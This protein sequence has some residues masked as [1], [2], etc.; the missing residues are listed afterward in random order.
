[1]KIHQRK[2]TGEKPYMCT[3]C[4]KSFSQ[5][6][7]LNTHKR[8]IHGN[9]GKTKGSKQHDIPVEDVY[10]REPSPE[11]IVD[12]KKVKYICATQ[13]N[14][15]NG[16][17][18]KC[19]GCSLEYNSIKTLE[20]H[21]TIHSGEKRYMCKICDKRFRTPRM[22]TEHWFTHKENENAKKFQCEKCAKIFAFKNQL[23]RHQ[24][25][26]HDEK[27]YG[28][29]HCPKKF[30]TVGI[31]TKHIKLKHKSK[32]KVHLCNHCG[33]GFDNPSQ[34][35]V[36]IRD[37][38]EEKKLACNECG[39]KFSGK[40]RL[41]RHIFYIHSGVEGFIPCLE[42]TCQKLFKV[43]SAMRN[44]HRTVHQKITYFCPICQ[45]PGFTSKNW[46]THRKKF[47]PE[48]IRSYFK[49]ETPTPTIL[50]QTT[51]KVMAENTDIFHA[52]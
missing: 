4:S 12:G 52:I 16:P 40:Y 41:Q 5:I 14:I 15:K 49:D 11:R 7:N 51:Q 2:H 20:L 3:F 50:D 26:V 8:N 31:L 25:D 13:E 38:H 24:K 23:T 28:C 35:K 37:I 48:L 10:V 18:F 45:V 6:S 44:H 42:E 30:S 27:I 21:Y 29:E 32:E 34:M 43:N 36:H 46:R 19:V 47:H 33:R 17:P 9:N 39:K 1:L 22:V